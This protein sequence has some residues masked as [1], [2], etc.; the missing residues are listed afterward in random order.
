MPSSQKNVSIGSLSAGNDQPFVLIAGPDS[1][2][3]PE[4]A[5]KMAKTIKEIADAHEV[6]YVFKA[7]YDKANRT[8]GSS[9]RGVGLEKGLEILSQVQQ[10]HGVPVTTDVHSP[11]E[12]TKAGQVVDLIQIPALLSRQTDLIEAGARTGKPLNIKKGQFMSPQDIH[13]PIGKAG[14]VGNENVLITERGFAF[15]YHNL[16]SDMRSLAIMKQTGF[17]VVFDASHSVQLPSA[18][19]EASGGQR[20]FIP[21]LARAAVAAGIA[22]LFVEVHDDPDNAPVDGAN[23]LDLRN[24][25]ELVEVLKGIDSIVKV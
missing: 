1:L 25:P 15:G 22:G 6:S 5:L 9:F 17:P 11:K 10:A 23:A 3:T 12:A 2:E 4:H 16:V 20:E 7:S 13:G 18:G 19:G 24:L 21:P 14:A 8:S